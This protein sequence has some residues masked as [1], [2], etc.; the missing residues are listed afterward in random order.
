[1]LTAT[2]QFFQTGG[3]MMWVILAVLATALGIILE[4]L[5]FFHFKGLMNS[6]ELAAQTAKRIV[7]DD[8]QAALDNLDENGGPTRRL[9]R[10]A[11]EEAW[12]GGSASEIRQVV[13]EHA[14]R[15]IP[16]FGRRLNY[17]A[18]LANVATLAGLL[19]TIFGLQ[20][21]FSSLA[22][23]D[24]AEKAS[25]LAAGISQAM[26]TTALGLMVAMPILLIHS[27]LTSMATRLTEECDAG[28]TRLL[29]FFSIREKQ[30]QNISNRRAV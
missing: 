15:E 8:F 27:R 5:Y 24:A 19:G 28:L 12:E 30:I 3:P 9:M 22:E 18:V 13:Q 17:L 25:V 4:R 21:S 11:V 20:Q 29:N 1:M 16:R 7:A 14:L 2:A 26:N 23:A 10:H 6:D